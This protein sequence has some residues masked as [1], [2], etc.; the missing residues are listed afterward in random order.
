MRKVLIWLTLGADVARDRRYDDVSLQAGSETR[1]GFNGLSNRLLVS[2]WK[3]DMMPNEL[4]SSGVTV[5]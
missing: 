1:G 3:I 5:K 4:H 2:Q